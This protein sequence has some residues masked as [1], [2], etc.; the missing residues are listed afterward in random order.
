MHFPELL[1]QFQ[2]TKR[3]PEINDCKYLREP[4]F[5][6]QTGNLEDLIEWMQ[7]RGYS[8]REKQL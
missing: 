7:N 4:D 5:L 6:P 3:L 2:T 1:R 8:K